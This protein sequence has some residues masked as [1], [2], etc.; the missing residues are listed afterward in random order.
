[1][2]QP[3]NSFVQTS[4]TREWWS[5]NLRSADTRT[6]VQKR[7]QYLQTALQAITRWENSLKEEKSKPLDERNSLDLASY[8]K[9]ITSAKRWFES[10]AQSL[11]NC[12][13]FA[14]A[15]ETPNSEDYAELVA[16]RSKAG[17]RTI[18]TAQVSKDELKELQV[19]AATVEEYI[20]AKQVAAGNSL[21][22]EAMKRVWEL[23]SSAVTTFKR[24]N[25][26]REEDDT[27]QQAALG[28]LRACEL[29]EPSG[30]K[31]A[32]LATYATHWIRRKVEARNG[33]HCKPGLTRL[34]GGKL[35]NYC[36]IEPSTSPSSEGGTQ[37]H[38]RPD[39]FHPKHEEDAGLKLDVHAAIAELGEA[40]RQVAQR[41]LLNGEKTNECAAAMGINTAKV[42][43]LLGKAKKNLAKL[44]VS[45]S[46]ES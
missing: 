6:V 42:R 45:H 30:Q 15:C 38:H 9:Q 41:V 33:S 32:K 24:S 27:A 18:Q 23:C 1:M 13:R 14:V 3:A 35:V 21:S 26:V 19:F 12:V 28:V 40:E 25:F 46:I 34:P 39:Q 37:G 43:S 5:L 31:A 8:A 36:S 16:K 22:N 7:R 4:S 20:L 17:I 29:Y 2:N 11:R 10:E 44:L